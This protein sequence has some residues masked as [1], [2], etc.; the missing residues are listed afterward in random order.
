MLSAP[1][2]WSE[3]FMTLGSILSEGRVRNVISLAAKPLNGLGWFSKSCNV[4]S[5]FNYQSLMAGESKHSKKIYYL[6]KSAL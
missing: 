4:V 5:A 2:T 1:E 3:S 6:R